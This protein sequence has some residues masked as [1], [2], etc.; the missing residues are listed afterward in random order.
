V[1]TRLRISANA[2]LAA[3][4]SIH[5]HFACVSLLPLPC[6]RFDTI[7]T[8]HAQ[9]SSRFKDLQLRHL[10]NINSKHNINKIHQ[11]D[12]SPKTTNT[13]KLLFSLLIIAPA[14]A[15]V[16]ASFARPSFALAAERPDSAGAVAAA[17]AAS[18]K[19]GAT[20]TEAR[21][22]WDGTLRPL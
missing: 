4:E 10:G 22:L 7:F 17:L 15:F 2:S 9:K 5:R 13:M 16:P 20:S 3:G 1:L 21:V 12:P 18:K 14:A 11:Q 6:R 19:F 8:P